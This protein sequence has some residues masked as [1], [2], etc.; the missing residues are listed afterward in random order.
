MGI[1]RFV[2]LICGVVVAGLGV[3]KAIL[4]YQTVRTKQDKKTNGNGAPDQGKPRS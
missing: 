4:E 3:A 2:E 1:V